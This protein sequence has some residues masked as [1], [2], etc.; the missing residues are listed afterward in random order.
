[1]SENLKPKVMF[2]DDEKNIID[3][4]K[5]MLYPMRKEWDM[6]FTTSG[7]KAL[8]FMKTNHVDVIISDMRMPEMDGSELLTIIKEKYP[9]TARYILSGYSDKDMIL[10]TID[11]A[12][13]FLSKPCNSNMIK[14]VIKKVLNKKNSTNKRKVIEY[15]SQIETMPTLP[16]VHRRLTRTLQ[17]DDYTIKT[18]AEIIQHD[19]AIAAKIMQLVNSTFFGLKRSISDL[20]EAVTYLGIDVIKA[21]IASVGTFS[22][23]TDEEMKT[24]EIDALYRHCTTCSMLCKNILKTVSADKV[25]LEEATIA[26]LLHDIGIMVLIKNEPSKYKVVYQESGAN[27]DFLEK[28]EKLMFKITHAEIGGVLL[29]QWGFSES[30]VN[31][32]FYHHSPN[33]SAEISFG[34]ANALSVADVLQRNPNLDPSN[35]AQ[36]NMSHLEDL[37]VINHIEEWKAIAQ[38]VQK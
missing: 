38:E 15:M 35:T 3:G 22:Q 14:R 29:E 18:I 23:F 12:D 28:N 4:M 6:I 8:E 24:F 26:G 13:Q 7:I 17:S 1:M 5:R 25:L 16:K 31:A 27:L 30:I 37:N 9:S 36:L 21:I 2:V 11:S 20:T 34:L 32:V 33:D 19:V 10:K